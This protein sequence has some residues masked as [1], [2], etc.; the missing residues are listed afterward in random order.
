MIVRISAG[1][2]FLLSEEFF[3][4]LEPPRLLIRACRRSVGRGLKTT[5]RLHYCRGCGCVELCLDTSA[6]SKCLRGTNKSNF[7]FTRHGLFSRHEFNFEFTQIKY[8]FNLSECA[9][10]IQDYNTSFSQDP[11]KPLFL[12]ICYRSNK[13]VPYDNTYLFGY[14]V[15]VYQLKL[16]CNI[17]TIVNCVILVVNCVVML[18]IVLFLLLIVL[19]CV[20]FVC[21]CVLYYCHRVST[22]LQ[23]INISYKQQ[24]DNVQRLR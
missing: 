18:L 13:I 16:L 12:D 10:C 9:H 17:N 8:R 4:A 24:I 23:L 22:Q 19:F 6:P 2:I 21:K 3:P 15:P 5:T 7:S 1:M 20:L 11:N 14:F